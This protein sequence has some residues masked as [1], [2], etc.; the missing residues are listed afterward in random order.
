[1]TRYKRPEKETAYEP[2]VV[3]KSDERLPVTSSSSTCS[4]LYAG[5]EGSSFTND[6]YVIVVY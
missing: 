2:L 4:F 1:M 3:G 6:V 5:G